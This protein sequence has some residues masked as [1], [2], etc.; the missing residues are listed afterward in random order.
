MG[1]SAAVA[2]SAIRVSLGWATEAADIDRFLAAWLAMAERA[3]P[4]ARRQP[5]A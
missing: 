5:A 1:A 3:R 4:L 2:G